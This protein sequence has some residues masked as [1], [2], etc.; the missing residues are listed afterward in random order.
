[1]TSKTGRTIPQSHAPYYPNTA[2]NI[3]S[4][5]GNPVGNPADSPL[6]ING[7][8]NSSDGRPAGR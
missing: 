7:T 2:G 3:V 6:I 4:S 8:E 5:P 1:M